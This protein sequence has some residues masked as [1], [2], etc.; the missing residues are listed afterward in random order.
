MSDDVFDLEN[1]PGWTLLK[2]LARSFEGEPDSITTI[3]SGKFMS[4]DTPCQAVK[5]EG[6]YRPTI[7]GSHYLSF[8]SL[9][10]AKLL[11]ND[12]EVFKITKN[13]DDQM[14]FLLGGTVEEQTQFEF[15]KGEEYKL[16][17]ETLAPVNEGSNHGDGLSLLADMLG[18]HLGFM[19][20]EEYERDSLAEAIDLA[21]SAETVVV[22]VGNTPQWET[23]GM[24]GIYLYRQWLI[25]HHQATI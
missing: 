23:E 1:K 8:S 7:S 12:Q 10:P 4:L 18:V 25:K 16:Y 15:I 3:P 21:K 19:L 17:V 22:F 20:Q 6:V 5:L 2:Y 13:S 14:G 9:G 24:A 11:I